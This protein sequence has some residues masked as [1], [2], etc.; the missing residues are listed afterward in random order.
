MLPYLY[1]LLEIRQIILYLLGVMIAN[2]V[3]L[4][5][6]FLPACQILPIFS[7]FTGSLLFLLLHC[8][9]P[10]TTIAHPTPFPPWAHDWSASA[11]HVSTAVVFI[12]RKLT[13]WQLLG[14]SLYY[15]TRVS[16]HY[17]VPCI[18]LLQPNVTAFTPAL[19][20]SKVYAAT[21]LAAFLYAKSR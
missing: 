2:V 21:C 3:C 15:G 20:I 17:P 6:A 19:A 8:T 14:L 11:R 1:L 10:F 5:L 18:L 4:V 9:L 7:S 12:W 16:W 13:E